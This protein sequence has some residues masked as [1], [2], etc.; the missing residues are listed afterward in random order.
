MIDGML[1][2]GMAALAQKL[3]ISF[4]PSCRRRLFRALVPGFVVGAVFS[5]S[6]FAEPT[7]PL[8]L[9]GDMYAAGREVP[10][11]TP[12]KPVYYFPIV[13]GYQQLGAKPS[14]EQP[15]SVKDTV[16]QLA[17]ALAH[18]GYLVSSEVPAPA[19]AKTPAHAGETAS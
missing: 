16:H 5:S 6:S 10:H 8:N 4:L 3:M 1:A 13:R 19:S 12:G 14:G 2:R 11:P 18:E 15:P 7:W 17:A 9:V